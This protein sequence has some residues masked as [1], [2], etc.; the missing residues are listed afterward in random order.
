MGKTQ[1]KLIKKCKG[2]EREVEKLKIKNLDLSR[3]L[4]FVVFFIFIV[5][6]LNL[7]FTYYKYYE[8]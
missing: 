3:S 6:F 8:V 2:L 4:K 7:F 5:M 1:E